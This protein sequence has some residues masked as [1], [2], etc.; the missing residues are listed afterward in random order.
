MQKTTPQLTLT[1]LIEIDLIVSNEAAGS[2]PYLGEREGKNEK[3]G[4]RSLMIDNKLNDSESKPD[5][6]E[7]DSGEPNANERPQLPAQRTPSLSEWPV[8]PPG[9]AI[10]VVHC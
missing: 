5:Y 7:A 8:S 3:A 2:E 6:N 1:G 10:V 4:E 9:A